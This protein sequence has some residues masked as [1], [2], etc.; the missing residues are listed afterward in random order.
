MRHAPINP[1]L[2]KSN[3]DRLRALLPPNSIVIVNANDL[4]PANADATLRSAPNSDLFY[5]TGVEQEESILLIFPDA[6]DE[7]H[8]ELLFLREAKPELELWEGH[9][10]SKDEAKKLT[11]IPRVHWLA[12]FRGIFQ[13]LMC[14]AEHVFLNSNEHPRAVVE[15]ETRDARFVADVRRRYPLHDYHRLGRL[16]HRLRIV[17]SPEEL[18]LMER[19]ISITHA[20][21]ERIAKFVK[22]GVHEFELEAEFIHELTRSRAQ[23]A[24]LPIIAAGKNSC[25][26]HYQSNELPCRNGDV[27]LLDI[28][29]SYANYN[30]D[31][32]RTIPVNGRFTK[33][34]RQVYEAVLRIQKALIAGLQIGRKWKDWQ[35]EAESLTEKELVDLG[36]LTTRQIK[37]QDK[38]WPA[39]KQY[40]MHGV[41]HPIGVD[42]HDYGFMTEPF[43]AGTVMTVEPGIYIPKEELGVRLEN[44]VL[45]T[46]N[47]PVDLMAQIPIE[48]EAIE[49]LMRK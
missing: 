18:K 29:A 45:L 37:K 24:Y 7:K 27:L 32:T 36:L 6:D 2:F 5:L 28:G 39:L 47:G 44:D 49:A 30:A 10:L 31:L 8:R 21:F 22:P 4:Q 48:P 1:E 16:M 12:D 23:F 9:K 35:K 42:V 20:G 40:F 11:G 14:Q 3:R 19:A 43:V 13:R 38:D 34:Q 26:L 41:G 17:K 25:C 33:R 46:E 15:V